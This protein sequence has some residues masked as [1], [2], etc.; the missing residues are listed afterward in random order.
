MGLGLGIALWRAACS[1]LRRRRAHSFRPARP[2]IAFWMA[3]VASA[4][5]IPNC[6]GIGKVGRRWKVEGWKRG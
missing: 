6:K 5:D 4:Y 3:A 2:R 1:L